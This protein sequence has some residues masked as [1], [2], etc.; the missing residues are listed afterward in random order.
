MNEMGGV[1]I[2]LKTSLKILVSWLRISVPV[3]IFEF[4][5]IA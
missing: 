2:I 1:L 3:G 5:L 4:I